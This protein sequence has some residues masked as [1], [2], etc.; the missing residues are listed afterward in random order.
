MA[1][2]EGGY[3]PIGYHIG[4]V[5]PHDNSL[6][7]AGLA[8]YG[9]HAEAAQ[10][11]FAM[12]EAAE[13]FNHRLPEAF[14][15]YSRERTLFPVE[16]PTAC[17]P[18]AW[19]TGAPLLFIRLLV[20]LEPNKH[21]RATPILPEGIS[22][23]KVV[24]D[25]RRRPSEELARRTQAPHRVL[26]ARRAL[27]TVAG[28]REFFTRYEDYVDPTAVPD[29]R[30]SHRFDVRGA[31]VWRVELD[32]GGVEVSQN[33][34]EADLMLEL[35]EKVFLDIVRGEQNPITAFLNGSVKMSGDFSLAPTLIRI[36]SPA[37]LG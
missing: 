4:T 7:A 3:N 16:Y 14:A 22:R 35:T 18:Q 5:W 20:G 23:L 36:Y 32:D 2:G 21:Q 12:L 31:G 29:L 33:A 19:A 34:E 24:I 10:I 13:F 30:G 27:T 26:S 17:S 37:N 28:V 25:G 9:F 8:R 11:A 6:V 15:G 1:D